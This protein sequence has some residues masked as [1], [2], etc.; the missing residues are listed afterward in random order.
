MSSLTVGGGWGRWKRGPGTTEPW[1]RNSLSAGCETLLKV[2][3]YVY[4]HLIVSCG[5]T[6]DIWKH[7]HIETGGTPSMWGL[8]L[9]WILPLTPGWLTSESQRPTCFCLGTGTASSHHRGFFTGLTGGSSAIFSHSIKNVSV[10]TS[11]AHEGACCRALWIWVPSPEPSQWKESTD[12]TSICV[13]F[14]LPCSLTKR[15]YFQNI[16]GFSQISLCHYVK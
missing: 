1:P 2:L 3:N 5:C 16:W 11:P 7:G 15:F 13:V 14:L 10:R 4:T 6:W 12:L 8:S 9:S